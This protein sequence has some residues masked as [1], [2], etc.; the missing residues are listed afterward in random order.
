MKPPVSGAPFRYP[1][2]GPPSRSPVSQI[3]RVTVSLYPGS[4]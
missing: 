3:P 2:E 4:Y 1:V